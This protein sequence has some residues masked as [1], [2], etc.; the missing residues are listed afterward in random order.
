MTSTFQGGCSCRA[1]R[2]RMES[3]PI[4]VNCCHCRWCQRETGSAFAVNA[5]IETDRVIVEGETERTQLPSASGRG[6]D[7]VRCA[8][9]QVAVFSSYGGAE[10]LAFVRVGTLD[11]PDSL[12]PDIHVW[13]MSKQPW[14]ALPEGARVMTE[15][16]KP[17]EILPKAAF[18]R[19]R[20][21]FN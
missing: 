17:R 21:L 13:T 20:A 12:P 11:N 7:V 1:V 18:E 6:Q 5:L 8:A 2:Y 15:Y 9:C 19:L 16:Y 3:D 14:V 10:K 4:I